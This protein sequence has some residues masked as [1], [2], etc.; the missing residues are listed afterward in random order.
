MGLPIGPRV[1][2]NDKKENGQ[3]TSYAICLERNTG[4]TDI[5]I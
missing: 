4:L 2:I 1:L 3:I 5:E